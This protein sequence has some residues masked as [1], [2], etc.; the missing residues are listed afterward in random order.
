MQLHQHVCVCVCV[1]VHACSCTCI[2]LFIYD[3]L[4]VSTSISLI[5]ASLYY[6]FFILFYILL[7][8]NMFNWSFNCDVML[9][10]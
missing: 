10:F 1:G 3:N 4:I 6:L 5:S 9:M 8:P 7:R 2:S